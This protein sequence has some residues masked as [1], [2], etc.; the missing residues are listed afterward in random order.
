MMISGVLNTQ[1]WEPSI[2]PPGSFA[3]R[4]ASE[5]IESGAFRHIPFL[6]GTNVG[7]NIFLFISQLI[8]S[9]RGA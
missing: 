5:V 1:L 7:L 9:N 6:A 2:G 3:E 8:I 4:R